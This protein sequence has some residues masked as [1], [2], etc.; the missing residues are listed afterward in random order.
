MLDG[1]GPKE[2]A[3]PNSRRFALEHKDF[4]M[5]SPQLSHNDDFYPQKQFLNKWNI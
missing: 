3:H 1:V 5:F 4:F 2:E